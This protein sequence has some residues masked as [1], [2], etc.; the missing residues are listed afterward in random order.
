MNGSGKSDWSDV[1]RNGAVPRVDRA[2]AH[3]AVLAVLEVADELAAELQV[4]VA[5]RVVG[6]REVVADLPDLLI[7]MARRVRVG[8]DR[9]ARERDARVAVG[10][11]RRLPVLRPGDERVVRKPV[12]AVAAADLVERAV[13]QHLRE[14]PD[15]FLVALVVVDRRRRMR[16]ST[17]RR[18]TDR[19]CFC[20]DALPMMRV[21]DES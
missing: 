8:V 21:F 14:L 6:H 7:A 12:V 9:K 13:A 17:S 20:P 15:V 1:R 11:A 5:L 10:D 3:R 2:A 18:R 19:S 4:V 16:S